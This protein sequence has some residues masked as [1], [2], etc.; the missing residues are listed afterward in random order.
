[1]SGRQAAC[2]RCALCR[3]SS[4]AAA[5]ALAQAA[6]V[7]PADEG[8]AP[9]LVL[10]G[11]TADLAGAAFS[12][13]GTKVVTASSDHTA[14]IWDA[15][16]GAVLAVLA[17]P[18]GR[19]AQ[20]RVQPRR[21]AHRHR[22]ARRQRPHLGCR[23]RRAAASRSSGTADARIRR[24]QPRRHARRHRLARQAATV[25]DAKTGE[26]IAD[27]L[28][29]KGP[30][31]R[32]AFSPD[33]SRVVTAST[34]QDGAHLG[35]RDGRGDRDARQA[36]SAWCWAPRSAPTAAKVVTAASDKTRAHLGRQDRRAA[37]S[38]CTGH[39]RA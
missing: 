16:T 31:M 24:L 20:R 21:H 9:A 37:S 23:H 11:H 2:V 28:G 17:G 22:L 19:R 5:L 33:G 15:K 1:M 35:R 7:R 25:W 29:H 34:R 32:A 4:A 30:V 12:P 10:K 38:R 6:P 26:A 39:E 36:T 18:R 3:G 13:D 8:P 14:R 27:L